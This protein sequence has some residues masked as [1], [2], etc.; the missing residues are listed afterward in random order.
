MATLREYFLKLGPGTFTHSVNKQVCRDDEVIGEVTIRLHYDF[1][2]SA[3]YVSLYIEDM[4]AV[5]CP[6]AIVLNDLEATLSEMSKEVPVAAGLPGEMRSG[7]DLT[8]TGRVY[9]YSERPVSEEMRCSLERDARRVG[10][11]LV[12]RSEEFLKDRNRLERPQA[13]ICHDSRDKESVAQPLALELQKMMCPVWFDEFSLRVG[14]SLRARI[15]KGLRECPKC[16]L[17]ITPR[18][19]SNEG[20][21]KREFDSI[22]TRELVEEKRVILP[23]WYGVSVGEA[24]EYSP[25][26][27]DRVAVNWELGKEEVA[28]KLLQAMGM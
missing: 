13:F 12:F 5:R 18:F 20:W 19:L 22:Y 23:V 8:F 3:K 11:S 10:H 24:Y 21:T 15:E 7:V 17:I 25:I 1:E 2:A 4:A 27:A 9:I 16:V 6:E 28:R 14:D 26:L